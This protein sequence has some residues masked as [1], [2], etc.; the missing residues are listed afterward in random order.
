LEAVNGSERP[1]DHNRFFEFDF[2]NLIT[3]DEYCR[4]VLVDKIDLGPVV[5]ALDRSASY[6]EHRHSNTKMQQLF[7]V[8]GV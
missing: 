1:L 2:Q 6:C 5:Q 7:K 8:H 4:K 3:S